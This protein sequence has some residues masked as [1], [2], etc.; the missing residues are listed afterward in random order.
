MCISKVK[1]RKEIIVAELSKS[2]SGE[3]NQQFYFCVEGSNNIAS[4]KETIGWV[5]DNVNT[6]LE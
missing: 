2:L 4:K 5:L 3:G 6:Q 1:I